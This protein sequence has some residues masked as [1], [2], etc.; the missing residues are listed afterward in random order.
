[1]K[2]L[3]LHNSYIYRGGEDAVVELEKNLTKIIK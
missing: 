2:I 1:M 3:Q